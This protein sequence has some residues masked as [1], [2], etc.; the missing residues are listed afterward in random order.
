MLCKCAVFLG[1]FAL[2]AMVGCTGCSRAAQGM[3]RADIR[4]EFAE[5][6]KLSR[7]D[8]Q[9]WESVQVARDVDEAIR[10]FD[11]HL[12]P[13]LEDRSEV[14]LRR[15][16]S[17]MA[18][19]KSWVYCFDGPEYTACY[20]LNLFPERCEQGKYGFKYFVSKYSKTTGKYVPEDENHGYLSLN[21]SHI[22]DDEG[23]SSERY[24]NWWGKFIKLVEPS[25]D[26]EP[27]WEFD[28]SDVVAVVDV[29]DV[30]LLR[31]SGFEQVRLYDA[32]AGC[33]A[34]Y[35][36]RMDVRA[37]E[38]GSLDC[39]TIMLEASLDWSSHGWMYYRGMTLKVGF[40]KRGTEYVI[41]NIK[42][43]L[44]YEP[45]SDADIDVSGGFHV[46]NDWKEMLKGHLSP[47]VVQYG[48]HT[49]V[50]FRHGEI[51]NNAYRGSFPDFGLT[52]NVKVVEL[53]E[54]SN[55]EF[56]EDAWFVKIDGSYIYRTIKK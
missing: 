39:S 41:D 52:A 49:K 30:L 1:L 53:T 19:K 36:V 14:R 56:W 44:P 38:K 43:A 9:C 10:M 18:A 24:E 12:L 21:E 29:V 7:S 6:L 27:C 45:F 34:A 23:P 20:L 46:G 54:G 3:S 33:R 40:H 26:D 15:L 5:I 35:L 22:S 50:E 2:S 25:D 32:F 8:E 28:N 37:V 51:M 47:L 4:Y 16:R 13:T 55:K 17:R 42:A 11:E 31:V 48:K